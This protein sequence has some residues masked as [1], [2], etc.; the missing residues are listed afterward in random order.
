MG[1]GRGG[2]KGGGKGRGRQ[3]CSHV[4]SLVE[5]EHNL[6]RGGVQAQLKLGGARG[7]TARARVVRGGASIVAMDTATASHA[8]TEIYFCISLCDYT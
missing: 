7:Q 1:L 3:S 8:S 6:P 5:L 4:T 2:G